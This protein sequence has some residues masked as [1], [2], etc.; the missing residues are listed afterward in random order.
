[1]S[2]SSTIVAHSRIMGWSSCL[3]GLTVLLFG[4]QWRPLLVV[5]EYRHLRAYLA[6]L[7]TVGLV[8][9]HVQSTLSFLNH[10]WTRRDDLA[11]LHGPGWGPLE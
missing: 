11:H 10:Y 4:N 6:A 5:L 1:M 2:H 9:D 7:P 8:V 3:P